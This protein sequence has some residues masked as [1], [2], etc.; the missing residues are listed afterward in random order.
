[1]ILCPSASNDAAIMG[2]TEFFAPLIFTLPF[3]GTF[4]VIT[5]LANV[6]LPFIHLLYIN[7]K[8]H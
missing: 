7:K 2:N 8:M 4:S 6:F 1:M 3:K 5:N